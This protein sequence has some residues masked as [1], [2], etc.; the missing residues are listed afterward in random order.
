[1]IVL[2]LIVIAQLGL[3]G[4]LGVDKF[5]RQPLRK[6]AL[7]DGHGLRRVH[8]KHSDYGVDRGWV[9]RCECGVGALINDYNSPSEE[10]ALNAWKK[11]RT[12]YA[13]LALESSENAYKVLYEDKQAELEKY[14][15]TCYC[16]DIH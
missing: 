15:E 4:W 5:R 16:K 1:M 9:W 10:R 14:K 11:H 3:I 6:G 2:W 12:L 7:G 8:Y 13:D